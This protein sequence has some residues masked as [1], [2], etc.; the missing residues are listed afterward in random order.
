[1]TTEVQRLISISLAKIA[2]S[3]SLKGGIS[4]HKNLLVATV[5]QKAR[6]IFMEEAFH[7]AHG[8]N[9]HQE[10]SKK[11]TQELRH[12]KRKESYLRQ[13]DN[14]GE[15]NES[16][17]LNDSELNP[18]I[19][20]SLNID[21]NEKV[22]ISNETKKLENSIC[23]DTNNEN[24]SSFKSTENSSQQPS[25]QDFINIQI[26]TSEN[27]NRKRRRFN[28]FDMSDDITFHSLKFKKI[29]LDDIKTLN[30]SENSKTFTKETKNTSNVN[31][32]N[33]SKYRASMN[34]LSNN[35]IN[36]KHLRNNSS[37]M[38]MTPLDMSNSTSTNTTNFSISPISSSFD[39]IT[40]HVP[41]FKFRNL[42][43][44]VSTPDLYSSSSNYCPVD[45]LQR[46][47]AMTV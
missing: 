30:K 44:S 11:I 14:N 29:K 24:V 23:D 41:I 22:N 45:C 35:S 36:E 2:T 43:R 10:N 25:H 34:F 20:T 1:M 42:Q 19:S 8:Y 4:L 46:Q 21:S 47:M 39:C 13:S 17:S 32:R 31:C 15:K 27:C 26:K 38:V 28:D 3:R 18:L 37:N 5:L 33:L 40:S 7:I 9:T 6:Y 16:F 12:E